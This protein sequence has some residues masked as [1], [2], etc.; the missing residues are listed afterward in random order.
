MK[1]VR[2]LCLGALAAGLGCG[3]KSSTG[4]VTPPGPGADEVWMQSSAFVPATRTVSVGTMV[5]FTNKDGVT[6][7]VTSSSVPGG[8][9]AISSGNITGSGTFQRT[10]SVAGSYQYYCTIHGSPGAGMRGTI[11]VN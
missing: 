9:A 4:T 7:T 2:L 6:H 1:L 8:A 11:T 10:F 5:T 3:S